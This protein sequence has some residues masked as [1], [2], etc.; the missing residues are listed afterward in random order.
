MVLAN[1]KG[2]SLSKEPVL[3]AAEVEMSAYADRGFFAII[4]LP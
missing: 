4:Y 3:S 2:F 1:Q